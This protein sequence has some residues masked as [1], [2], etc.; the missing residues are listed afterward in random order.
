MLCPKVILMFLR[1][2]EFFSEDLS[3]VG[4][5][6]IYT[7]YATQISVWL[8]Y[9][10]HFISLQYYPAFLYSSC[11]EVAAAAGELAKVLR[12]QDIKML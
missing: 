10:F 12:H 9:L 4:D 2:K 6:R 11:A 1:N 5:V 7:V 3:R 8:S